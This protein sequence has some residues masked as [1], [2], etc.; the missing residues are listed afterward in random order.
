MMKEKISLPVI[1]IFRHFVT[2]KCLN[3]KINLI[4]SCE[5]DTKSQQCLFD[6]FPE[7]QPN[8]FYWC[9]LSE[10]CNDDAVDSDAMSGITSTKN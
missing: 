10:K 4:E 5:F 6:P 3:E 1:N 9:Q 8:F 7:R 2:C